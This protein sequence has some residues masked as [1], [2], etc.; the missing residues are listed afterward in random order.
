MNAFPSPS[1]G[2]IIIATDTPKNSN[3]K[4]NIP[5]YSKKTNRLMPQAN[6]AIRL[7]LS[8]KNSE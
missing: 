2:W 6:I 1:L 3:G 8:G 7:P 5:E 4:D